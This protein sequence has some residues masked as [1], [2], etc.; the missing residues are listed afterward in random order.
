MK[1]G[2]AGFVTDG[3]L[4]DTPD[5]AKLDLPVYIHAPSAPTNLI[6]HHAVDINVPIG[7]AGVPVFPGDIMV[8]DGEGVVVIP[9]HLAEDVAN[10]G[11]EMTAYEDFVQECVTGGERIFGLYPA[12]P[13][14]RERF[15]AW[16]QKNGR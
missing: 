12:T 4:R 6:H 13:E 14:S 11:F 10:E 1:R 5:I 7:C 8:G 16:R 15:K 2:A 3:G 9:A